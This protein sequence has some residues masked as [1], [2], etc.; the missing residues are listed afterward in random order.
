[1]NISTANKTYHEGKEKHCGWQLETKKNQLFAVIISQ[2]PT[3]SLPVYKLASSLLS[4][5]TQKRVISSCFKK[6][7]YLAQLLIDK[8]RKRG[9]VSCAP[10][11]NPL[12]IAYFEELE[13][14]VARNVLIGA[15]LALCGTIYFSY[16]Y[17]TVLFVQHFSQLFPCGSQSL[18]MAAPTIQLR[19]EI[20]LRLS[21]ILT[22]GRR[23]LQSGSFFLLPQK[24][25]PHCI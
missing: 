25:C 5:R 16:S 8:S 24:S 12:A 13:S 14:G 2:K 11:L 19:Y 21:Q 9:Q 7:T 20:F 22:M 1:M 10:E 3:V 4:G 23:T 17:V 6:E 18:A 15:H